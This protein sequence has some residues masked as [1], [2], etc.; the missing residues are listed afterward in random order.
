MPHYIENTGSEGPP[1]LELFSSPN[2]Q[3]ASLTN[4]MA[5]TPRDRVAQHLSVNHTFI[6][7]LPHQKHHVL[8]A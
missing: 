1:Y 7:R 5:A 4:R 6:D 8:P 3:D 2:Y